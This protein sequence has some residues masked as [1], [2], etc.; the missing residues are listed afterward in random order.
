M[1][2]LDTLK[3]EHEEMVCLIGAEGN[4]FLYQFFDVDLVMNRM[5]L[6][7]IFFSST[8]AVWLELTAHSSKN[9]KKIAIAV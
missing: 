1:Q 5:Q 2:L 7:N 8:G 9:G 4:I 3:F 6:I